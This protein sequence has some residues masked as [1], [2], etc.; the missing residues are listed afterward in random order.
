MGGSLIVR[1]HANG[2]YAI[3]GHTAE[4][5]QTT[6]QR[7]GD[8][9]GIAVGLAGLDAEPAIGEWLVGIGVQA[10][11]QG[12]TVAVR[13]VDVV[14]DLLAQALQLLDQG[15][16]LCLVVGAVASLHQQTTEVL[17]GTVDFTQR[18]FRI[19]DGGLLGFELALVRFNAAQ[20]GACTL[21]LR[22]GHRVVAGANHAFDGRGMLHLAGQFGLLFAD[23]ADGPVVHV[24]CT[25]AR[26]AHGVLLVDRPISAWC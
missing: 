12:Q 13:A 6:V 11:E 24:G 2:Q 4:E 9:V 23:V 10:T 22:G 15:V 18:R 19:G 16:A 7:V 1:T 8:G 25:E 20:T 14:Q 26:N 17:H 3:A 21:G 5:G